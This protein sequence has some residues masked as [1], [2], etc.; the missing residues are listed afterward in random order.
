MS[1]GLSHPPAKFIVTA[2]IDDN[3]YKAFVPDIEYVYYQHLGREGAAWQL[4]FHCYIS[5]KREKNLIAGWEQNPDDAF[6]F[7]IVPVNPN[8]YSYT[9]PY[10]SKAVFDTVEEKSGPITEAHFVLSVCD[11][12]I[13][14]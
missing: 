5:K 10:M 11:G 8:K 3:E 1:K 13:I 7:T 9:R 2:T 6:R 12:R 14:K 4:K